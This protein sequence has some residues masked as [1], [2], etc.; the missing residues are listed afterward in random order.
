[1]VAGGIAVTPSSIWTKQSLR[2]SAVRACHG[3]WYTPI[4]SRRK[5]LKVPFRWPSSI[6]RLLLHR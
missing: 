5:A 6:E 1:M 4:G 2:D 3:H